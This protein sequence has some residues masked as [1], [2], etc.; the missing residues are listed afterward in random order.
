M[1]HFCFENLIFISYLLQFSLSIRFPCSILMMLL[2]LCEQKF[3]SRNLYAIFDVEA[4]ASQK[5]S[6][7]FENPTTYTWYFFTNKLCL[8]FPVTKAYHRKSLLVH[9][10]TAQRGKLSDGTTINTSEKF[11]ILHK[12]YEVLM[13]AEKRKLY[14][15]RGIVVNETSKSY[16]VTDAQFE[17]CRE[18]YAGIMFCLICDF[19]LVIQFHFQYLQD[20]NVRNKKSVMPILMVSVKSIT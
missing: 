15:T 10:D 2:D 17:E 14:D 8:Y 11:Q 13:D 7:S 16:V 5:K 1:F 20:L 12:A 9:P 4:T 19:S 6:E 3:G 18:K